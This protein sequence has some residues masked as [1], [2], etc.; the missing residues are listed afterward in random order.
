MSKKGLKRQTGKGK[1]GKTHRLSAAHEKAQTK[2]DARSCIFLAIRLSAV[3]SPGRKCM[4]AADPVTYPSFGKHAL[5]DNL[6]VNVA[7]GS[8]LSKMNRKG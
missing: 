6:A 7:D 3:S 5:V 1:E 2:L 4:N 8:S